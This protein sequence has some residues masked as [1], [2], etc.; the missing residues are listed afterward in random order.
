MRIPMDRFSSTQGRF[1]VRF[2]RSDFQ[3]IG[4]S[5]PDLFLRVYD[6]SGTR[7]IHQTADAIRW[8]ASPS[9]R[10]LLRI[11]ARLLRP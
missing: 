9:E 2:G 10:Y 7:E 1:E 6:R 11:P 8:N 3:D 4:E 5:R